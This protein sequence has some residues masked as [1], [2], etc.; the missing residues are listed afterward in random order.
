[1][2]E[3]ARPDR[4]QHPIDLPTLGEYAALLGLHGRPA[5]DRAFPAVAGHLASGC[6]ACEPD[7]HEMLTTLAA[8]RGQA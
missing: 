2:W 7:L 6:S 3:A 4:D 8:E 1:L 5:A